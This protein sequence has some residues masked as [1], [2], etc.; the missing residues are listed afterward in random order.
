MSCE[1][2]RDIQRLRAC[3]SSAGLAPAQHIAKPLHATAVCP[4]A[5]LP[6]TSGLFLLR[7]RGS[8]SRGVSPEIP[9]DATGRNCLRRSRSGRAAVPLVEHARVRAAY[10]LRAAPSAALRK[11]GFPTTAANVPKIS[12]RSQPAS[13]RTAAAPFVALTRAGRQQVLGVEM[14]AEGSAP[15]PRRST[16]FCYCPLRSKPPGSAL[17]DCRRPL[18]R[19]MIPRPLAVE[20]LSTQNARRA[21]RF[22]AMMPSGGNQCRHA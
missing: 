3:F 2:R 5:R 21:N 17:R 8:V 10:L 13:R 22:S 14:A 4:A 12:L 6:D 16:R 7:A 15:P 18:R 1:H 19:M 20:P 11:S 9:P